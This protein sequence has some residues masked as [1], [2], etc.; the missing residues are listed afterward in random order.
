MS[1]KKPKKDCITCGFPVGNG[2]NQHRNGH[3]PPAPKP[4]DNHKARKTKA[5]NKARAT[6]PEDIKRGA[7]VAGIHKKA[8]SSPGTSKKKA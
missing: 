4:G 1:S 8:A 7:P 6:A 3:C 2:G 5:R